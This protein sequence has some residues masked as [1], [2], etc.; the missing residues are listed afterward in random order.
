M[1]STLNWGGVVHALAFYNQPQHVP[2]SN[3]ELRAEIDTRPG[4]FALRERKMLDALGLL[5]SGLLG[6]C[7]RGS[8]NGNAGMAE[9]RC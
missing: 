7:V 6:R 8:G 4:A 2:L 3:G 9:H 5:V 1:S